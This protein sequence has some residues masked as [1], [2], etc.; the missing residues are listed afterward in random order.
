MSIPPQFSLL[1]CGGQEVFI[2]LHMLWDH[3][4]HFYVC[5]VV[6][7]WDAKESSETPHFHCLDLS[8]QFCCQCPWL[9][10]VQE[11]DWTNAWSNFNFYWRQMF[12]SFHKGFSFA[13]VVAVCAALAKTSV[14]DP[15]S[16][17]MAPRYLN[18]FTV[19]SSCSLT[20][21][22]LVISVALF[23]INFVF[24]AL[25]SMPNLNDV[26]SRRCTRLRNLLYVK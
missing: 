7:V 13:S 21:I 2:V 15:S 20:V 16:L 11:V 23:V 19:S 24:P 25:I 18:W 12:L 5:D 8:L 10:C 14:F 26:L 6:C 17:S 3:S 9:I 22:F 1:H 4:A